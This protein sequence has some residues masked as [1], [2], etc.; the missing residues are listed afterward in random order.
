PYRG[1]VLQEVVRTLARQTSETVLV[2]RIHGLQMQYVAVLDAKY[3]LRYTPRPG[4]IRPLHRSGVGI[5]LLSSF[6]EAQ[7]QSLLERYNASCQVKAQKAEIKRVMR[8]VR[9]AR[10]LSYYQSSG[11]ATPGA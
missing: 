7:A 5:A 2:G 10:Q 11:L 1:D 6:S 3:D 4:T 9:L 8:E